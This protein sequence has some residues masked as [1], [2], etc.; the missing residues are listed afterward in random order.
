MAIRIQLK[1]EGGLGAFP[2]LAKPLMVDEQ[3]LP[4]E[5]AQELKRLL[6]GVRFFDLPPTVGAPLPGAAD[7][8]RHTITASDDA[9]THTVSFEDP[10]QN[11]GLRDLRDFIRLHGA[12]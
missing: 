10:V 7:Y 1:T 6:D 5:R 9:R 3:A 2:G 8:Q 12:R 4:A 11:P